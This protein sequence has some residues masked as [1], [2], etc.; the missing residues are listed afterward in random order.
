MNKGHIALA[1]V[2]LVLASLVGFTAAQYTVEPTVEYIPAPDPLVGNVIVEEPTANMTAPTYPEP[3]DL[4]DYLVGGWVEYDGGAREPRYQL[5]GTDG[6]QG[7]GAIN[8]ETG[9]G[10]F[11]TFYER[12]NWYMEYDHLYLSVDHELDE[13]TE[14]YVR[15]RPILSSEWI[16]EKID[17]DVMRMTRIGDDPISGGMDGEVFDYIR[18]PDS[19]MGQ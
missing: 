8:T 4:S 2:G 16:I 7:F 5:C 15:I 12:G 1:G 3:E 6:G 10:L 11:E 17:E 18:C 19:N 9:V 13:E 14:E